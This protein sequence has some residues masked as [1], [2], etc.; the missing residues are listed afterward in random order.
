[1]EPCMPYDKPFIDQ[2]HSVN[3]ARYCP[4]SCFIFCMSMGS[5]HKRQ[6]NMMPKADVTEIRNNDD[7]QQESKPNSFY[8]L[9]LKI[10]AESEEH[11]SK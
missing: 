4:W 11:T 9:G 1:M 2:A 3:M 8:W 10:S 5:T 7:Q 6:V